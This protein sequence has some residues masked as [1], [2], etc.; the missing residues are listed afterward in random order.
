LL[1]SIAIKCVSILTNGEEIEKKLTSWNE[2][3]YKSQ[4]MD[5]FL[6]PNTFYVLASIAK[7]K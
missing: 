5:G 4:A 1:Q 3:A 7:E 2:V 6:G